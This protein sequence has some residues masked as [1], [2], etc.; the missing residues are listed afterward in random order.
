[1]AAAVS[2]EALL[3][4]RGLG[5]E[6]VDVPDVGTVVVRGLSRAEVV[7]LASV[8][9]DAMEIRTIAAGMVEPSLTYEEV[10]AWRKEASS[11]VIRPISDAILTLSGLAEGSR[12]EAERSFR[13]GE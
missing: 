1:M 12:H 13:P 2:K 5:T 3:A 10:E 7:A 4:A 11:D 8:G 6:S 9:P